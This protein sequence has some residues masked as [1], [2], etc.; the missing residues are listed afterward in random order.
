ME[1]TDENSRMWSYKLTYDT[2]FAPNPFFDV[3]TLATCK[4][5][6]RRSPKSV[7]GTWIAGWTAC[8]IHNADVY[9]GGI[10]NCKMGEEKLIYLAQIDENITLDE[11]WV[12]FPQKRSYP[13]CGDDDPRSCGDN[14]YHGDKTDSDGNIV[15]EDNKHGHEGAECALRDYFYGKNALICRRF[16]YFPKDNRLDVPDKFRALVHKGI[17]QKLISDALV[18]EFIAY[19]AAQAHDMGVEN[20]IVG[21]MPM[22]IETTAPTAP[23]M[24]ISQPTSNNKPKSK[25]C[26][27]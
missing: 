11:Y 4:P 17:G 25:G 1:K 21:S 13:E 24:P 12:R 3:L 14:I 19:V 6:I 20:G 9:G 7:P 2:M 23:Q 15:A 5:G 22:K 26:S 8:N 16:Y 10:D 18:D 27:K